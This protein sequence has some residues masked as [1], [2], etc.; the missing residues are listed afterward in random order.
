[1]SMPPEYHRFTIAEYL[2][3][4]ETSLE[5]HEFRDGQILMMPGGTRF[6]SL[7]ITNV[8][9]ELRSALRGKPCQV[10]DSNLRVRIPRKTLFTYPDATVIC[11][12]YRAD[13]DDRSSGTALNPRLIVEVLSTSTEG[14]DRGEKFNR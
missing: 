6:H 9:S 5:K 12:E 10:Y 4:E 1:M 14:Y 3:Q 7:I 2:R 13:P 8:L 11:G